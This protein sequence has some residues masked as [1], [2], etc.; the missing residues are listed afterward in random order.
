M[1]M[2]NYVYELT[3]AGALIGCARAIDDRGGAPFGGDAELHVNQKITVVGEVDE[4]RGEHTFTLKNNDLTTD[5]RLLVIADRPVRQLTMGSA[6][7]YRGEW[8]QIYG[9]V[10]RL[11]V[12]DMERAYGFDL[13]PDLEVVYGS[14]P[15]VVTDRILQP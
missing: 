7:V 13:D 6:V 12:P 3:L 5:E 8:L 2:R 14:R 11:S 10:R 1:L 15:V 9:T 4:V